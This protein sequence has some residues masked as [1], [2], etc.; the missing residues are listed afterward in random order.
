MH[1]FSVFKLK[2]EHL[3]KL[4]MD[5]E[6]QMVGES[7]DLRT[8][9]GLLI[10]TLLKQNLAKSRSTPRVA[11]PQQANPRSKKPILNLNLFK[12]HN[13]NFLVKTAKRTRRILTKD[14]VRSVT[15]SDSKTSTSTSVDRDS[16]DGRPP[17]N[18]SNGS[19]GPG[20]AV[21]SGREQ[22]ADCG[23]LKSI[24]LGLKSFEYLLNVFDVLENYEN[25]FYGP[26]VYLNVQTFMLQSYYCE[27]LKNHRVF[28]KKIFG[29]NWSRLEAPISGSKGH[30]YLG[31]I[32]QIVDR[33]V[34]DF[35]HPQ[36]HS[37]GVKEEEVQTFQFILFDFLLT[38]IIEIYSK[39]HSCSLGGRF[40]MKM[41]LQE[42]LGYMETHVSK[43][44]AFALSDKFKSFVEVYWYNSQKGRLT[45]HLHLH[46]RQLRLL[47]AG[48]D[49]MLF[50]LEQADA[51]QRQIGA[52]RRAEQ[53][54]QLRRWK[55]LQAAPRRQSRR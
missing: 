54:H 37:L 38:L 12:L 20:K 41:D 51:D 27:L 48:N 13:N 49:E 43:E 40:Q 14:T 45:R 31:D 53:N 34:F 50:I 16:N 7:Q 10:Q 52:G 23:V 33:V 29:V 42:I 35:Q 9:F 55:G 6:T 21:L 18:H 3:R 47:F 28:Q 22:S 2:N 24:V 15:N 1:S 17:L 25:N 4:L 19:I 8:G 39:I 44:Q 46:H 30:P 32:F 36:I 5:F 11:K 26:D